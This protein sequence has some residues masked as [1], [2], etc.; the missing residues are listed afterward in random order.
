MK[1]FLLGFLCAGAVFM[2]LHYQFIRTKDDLI[3][4]RKAEIGLLNT[5][6]DI[7]KWSAGDFLK[8]PEI[9]KTLTSRGIGKFI[10]QAIDSL[11]KS[12]GEKAKGG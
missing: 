9:T 8:N 7:R 10:D 12:E 4:A 5:L 2:A 6:V 11:P 1:S 3:I